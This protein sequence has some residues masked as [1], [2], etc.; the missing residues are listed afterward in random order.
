MI[1]LTY[2]TIVE[3]L[4][5][6]VAVVRNGKYL[7]N[8]N[9]AFKDFLSL[10][11]DVL[12]IKSLLL[13]IDSDTISISKFNIFINYPENLKSSFI[14]NLNSGIVLGCNLKRLSI[15]NVESLDLL[16]IQDLTSQEVRIRQLTIESQQDELTGIANRR[17]FEYEFS[18]TYE[19]ALRT[20]ITGA[21]I[22]LDLDNFKSINDRFGHSTGDSVLKQVGLALSPVVR[23]YEMLARVGGDEFAILISHSGEEA[24]ERLMKQIPLALKSVRINP[25][26]T[27]DLT[28]TLEISMGY[29]VFPLNNSSNKEVYEMADK[30]MYKNKFSSKKM[31]RV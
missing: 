4:D 12:D 31:S 16:S 30:I 21:L 14:L 9:I 11:D 17:K 29:C 22:L 5:V 26:D 15:D 2:K 7:S 20:N 18:R 1:M 8:I 25:Y 10:T 6:G 13:K 28:E 24:I 3:S 23:N 19:F 27:T